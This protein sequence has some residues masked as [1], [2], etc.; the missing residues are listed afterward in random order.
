M[1]L[2]G[3][4]GGQ[5]VWE[6]GGTPPKAD[7]AEDDAEGELEAEADGLAEAEELELA[8]EVPAG[9]EA[10]SSYSSE[11]NRCFHEPSS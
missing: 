11:P 7:D 2:I 6:S 4:S 1:P 8:E 5:V 9:A 10:R 3:A